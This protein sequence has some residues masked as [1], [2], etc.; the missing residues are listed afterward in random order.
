MT[1]ENLPEKP[2]SNTGFKILASIYSILKDPDKLKAL[3]TSGALAICGIYLLIK[4]IPII[5]RIL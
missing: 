2:K 1:W 5:R 3:I 4:I